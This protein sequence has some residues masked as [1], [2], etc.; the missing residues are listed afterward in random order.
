MLTVKIGAM[1]RPLEHRPLL[2]LSKFDPCQNVN[3]QEAPT[4]HILRHKIHI[5]QHDSVELGQGG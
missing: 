4:L 5:G 1:L 3:P 2:C